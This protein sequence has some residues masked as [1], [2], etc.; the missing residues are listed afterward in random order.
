MT[1]SDANYT[2][3]RARPVN[4]GILIQRSGVSRQTIH[5]YLRKGLLPKPLRTSRTYAL[6]PPEAVDL[7]EL[8]K[9]CQSE[10]RLSLDE[11]GKIFVRA[12]FNPSQ[13]CG[14]LERRDSSYRSPQSSATNGY[15]VLGQSEVIAMLQ[16]APPPD[17]LEKLRRQG[18]VSGHGDKYTHETVELVRTIWTLCQ[19]GLELD[20]LKD[21][22]KTMNEQAEA[23]L[24][25]FRRMAKQGAKAD[26][27]NA[28]QVLNTF[29]EFIDWKRKDA[30]RTAFFH[31]LFRTADTF[32]V[33]PNQKR[34]IPSETFL[35][36]MGLNREI[37]RLLNV[38]DNNP[39]DI[40]SLKGLARAYHLRS[41]Y[42]NLYGATEKILQLDPHD[43]RTIV[44]HA[45]AMS[46]LGRIDEAVA[47]LERHL[48]TKSD[49]LLKF[50]FGQLLV[51]RARNRGI[52]EFLSAVIRKQQLT[53]DSLREA[54]DRPAIRRW[55]T[56]DRALDNLTIADP[57]HLDEPTV[58]EM[59][60]LYQEYQSLSS[61]EL[62][63][64]SKISLA[65]GKILAAYALHLVYRRHHDPR[66]E[67]VRR[68]IAQMD[69]NG[70]LATRPSHGSDANSPSNKQQRSK[71][72]LQRVG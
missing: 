2:R 30:L 8:I 34:I 52:P 3:P 64:L 68:K 27:V 47:T 57:L 67:Q 36:K 48:E 60:A 71:A 70:V 40:R 43:V 26:Y 21:I 72:S 35:A 24:A 65:V 13:I 17:W 54:R 38:L 58:E 10:L 32:V 63:A 1:E 37:D 45:R 56:L 22:V 5:F 42:L 55:I 51:L 50:R 39:E 7:L 14:E 46:R 18:F 33:G 69:P 29:E 23:E 62:S 25:A 20:D 16:P 31:R 53:A 44:D 12:N 61:K 4:M 6:Y 41:D 15:R 9:Q 49:P 66:A 28:I 59:E 11:I 19:I